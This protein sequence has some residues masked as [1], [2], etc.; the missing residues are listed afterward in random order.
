MPIVKVPGGYRV[1]SYTTGKLF[2]KKY[3]T[4]KAAKAKAATSK[5]RSQR[6]RHTKRKGRY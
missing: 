4:K 5:R 3:K 1:R 6:K 2:K